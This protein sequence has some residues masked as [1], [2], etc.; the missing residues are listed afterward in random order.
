MVAS[1]QTGTL[2]GVAA[3]VAVEVSQTRGLPGFDTSYYWRL[4]CAESCAYSL[5]SRTAASSHLSTLH[6]ELAPA[7]VRSPGHRSISQ[8]PSRYSRH[9]LCETT[10]LAN[11]DRGRTIVGW[12]RMPAGT[13]HGEARALE[14]LAPRSCRQMMLAGAFCACRCVSPST[15]TTWWLSSVLQPQIAGPSILPVPWRQ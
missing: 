4:R 9:G 3:V 11:V 14:V 8:S 15:S 2:S 6:R 1:V 7:D 13:A 5:R 12:A 10:G